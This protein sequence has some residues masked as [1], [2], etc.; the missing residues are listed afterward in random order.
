M[1]ATEPYPQHAKMYP[2]VEANWAIRDFFTF[3]AGRGI[4]NMGHEQLNDMLLEFRG[5]DKL[6]YKAEVAQMRSKYRWLWEHFESRLPEL[7]MV[8]DETVP[9][10]TEAV[11]PAVAR[12]VQAALPD[13]E[14]QD[15]LSFLLER[16]R[17][18]ND[19]HRD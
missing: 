19:E 14:P 3:L 1:P 2:H 17:G 15:G 6:E 9:R 5:V 8:I 10:V 11:K 16:I 4:T 18:G 13:K 12:V 7:G